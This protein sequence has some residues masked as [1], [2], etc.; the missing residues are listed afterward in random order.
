MEMKGT[1]EGTMFDELKGEEA[2]L[3]TILL[4]HDRGTIGRAKQGFEPNLFR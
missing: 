1:D 2:R 4:V 3:L